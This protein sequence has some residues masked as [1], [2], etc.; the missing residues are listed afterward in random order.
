[1]IG[2]GFIETVV[3]A[4][5]AAFALFIAAM[6]IG[7]KAGRKAGKTLLLGSLA[8]FVVVVVSAYVVASGSGQLD[9]FKA[10]VG[11]DGLLQIGVFMLMVLFTTYFFASRYLDDLKR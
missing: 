7:A 4:G 5:L 2:T 10:E 3:V 8:A 11:T 9:V 1:L 6:P